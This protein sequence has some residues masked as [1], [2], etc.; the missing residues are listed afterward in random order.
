MISSELFMQE[1]LANLIHLSYNI[2]NEF[3]NWM[4]Y[5]RHPIV[6]WTQESRSHGKLSQ[7][8]STTSYGL[9]WIPIRLVLKSVSV[10]G[11][12]SWHSGT[13]FV[14]SEQLPSLNIFNNIFNVIQSDW[15]MIDILQAGKCVL[16][17]YLYILCNYFSALSTSCYFLIRSPCLLITR[18]INIVVSFTA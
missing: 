7:N 17:N 12:P 16:Q 5:K 8:F 9:W 1:I 6:S 3:L 10:I 2:S 13:S 14:L 4:K 18:C 11:I 15:V